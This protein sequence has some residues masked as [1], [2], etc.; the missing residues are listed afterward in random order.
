MGVSE[1][2]RVSSFLNM[3]GSKK[4]VVTYRWALKRFFESVY[5]EC[6]D[7]DECAERYFSEDRDY[8]ADV[9]NFFVSI[10]D[11]PPKSVSIMLTAVKSFLIEN[12]VEL[13]ERFWRRLRKRRKGNRALTLDKVPSNEELRRIIVHM[14]IHG[15][16]LYLLLASSGMR[17]GEALKLR[18]DDVDLSKR[19]VRIYI[20]GEYTKTGNPRIAFASREAG[21][22][23]SEWIKVRPKY[24]KAA[25]KKSRYPRPEPEKD[26]RLFPFQITTAYAVWKNALDKAGMNE[27]DRSTNIHKLHPHVLR[28]FFRTRLG[29]VLPLDVVEAL[30]GHEG[31]LTEVYRRYSEEEL[32]KFYL[33]GE[34]TLLIMATTED[35]ERVRAEVEERTKQLQAL[36]NGLVEEN[37]ELKRRLQQTEERL[38]RLEKL[39]SEAL[40]KAL[41]SGEA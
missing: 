32:A 6:G 39:L 8:E 16:A 15:K 22:A 11:R 37:L 31:Y 24:L 20:R 40:E 34:H 29:A 9:N 33:K 36:I 30:M 10:R 2:G 12:G 19:P 38:D 5:G 23:L 35:I 25:Y 7:L 14:P 28:K 27:R 26:D 21:E 13:S 3:Y 18:L 1:M 41:D 4:T 17:I